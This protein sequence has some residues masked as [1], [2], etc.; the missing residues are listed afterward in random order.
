MADLAVDL[1]ATVH[2]LQT[3]HRGDWDKVAQSYRAFLAFMRT[4]GDEERMQLSHVD[5]AHYT[6][7]ILEH[8]WHYF[9]WK[10]GRKREE[11]RR[12]RATRLAKKQEDAQYERDMIFGGVAKPSGHNVLKDSLSDQLQKIQD[13]VR[14]NLPT[15][16]M[17]LEDDDEGDSEED[18]EVL[19]MPKIF[20][21]G[22]DWEKAKLPGDPGWESGDDESSV[23]PP[24]QH[25]TFARETLSAILPASQRLADS[26]AELERCQKTGPMADLDRIRMGDLSALKRGFIPNRPPRPSECKYDEDDNDDAGD[27]Y[28]TAQFFKNMPAASV[29]AQNGTRHA[30]IPNEVHPEPPREVPVVRQ[31][32]PAND[33]HPSTGTNGN[34]E[35]TAVRRA[36]RW[37][38]IEHSD[39]SDDDT[40]LAGKAGKA[41]KGG[42]KGAGKGGKGCK[43]SASLRAADGGDGA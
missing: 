41:G 4:L 37:T 26:I 15:I 18:E 21:S 42:K 23:P 43:G 25:N 9:C 31:P 3:K 32:V 27:E 16:A 17:G 33:P 10:A 40:D 5:P 29:P 35:D 12:E 7:R 20:F 1:D 39:D 28:L 13:E 19:E 14:R 30:D 24:V 22:I 11:A 34:G 8:R 2:Y 38:V 6:P 36:G